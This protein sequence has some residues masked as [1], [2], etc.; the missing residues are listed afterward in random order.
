MSILFIRLCIAP[1]VGLE[2]IAHPTA[3]RIIRAAAGAHHI[4]ALTET[5]SL[6]LTSPIRSIY[7]GTR[8]VETESGRLYE[9][10]D[11]PA[12]DPAMVELLMVRPVLEIQGGYE[13]VSDEVWREMVS[14]S[15]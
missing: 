9:I 3:W 6:R 13:D 2:P 7:V 11:G 5:G 8:T 1:D 12:S 14:S 15:H 10:E 4:V